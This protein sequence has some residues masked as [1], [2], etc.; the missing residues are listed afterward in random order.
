RIPDLFFADGN[1]ILKAGHT[2]FKI[3]RHFLC[4]RSS[5]FR[6]M[7]EFPP[8]QEGN[9]MWEGCVVVELWDDA[10]D[11]EVFL[12]ALMDSSFFEPPP[13][14]TTIQILRGILRLST[15]YD[16]PYL[17]R[18]SILHLESTF[19]TSLPAWKNR[20]ETRTLDAID[21]TP[22]AAL[23]LAREMSVDWVIPAILYCVS[24]H[25][26]DKVLDGT[27]FEGEEVDLAWGD[28]KMCVVRRREL[29]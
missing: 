11:V 17:R 14:K 19:P 21:N 8:P 1:L 3:Y 15:K 20:T 9:L 2:I 28:K 29:L 22:F 13:C 27:T 6:D 25:P 7:F 4:A 5:V 26:L 16:V 23:Q 18:R 12:R 10:R 24:S